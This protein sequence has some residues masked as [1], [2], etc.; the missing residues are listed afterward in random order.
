MPGMTVPPTRSG[1]AARAGWL[2]LLL[3]APGPAAA[4]VLYDVAPDAV[5]PFSSIDTLFPNWLMA[6][7]TSL[8]LLEG[9]D[10]ID[11]TC[12][13]N[14]LT[15]MNYGSAT[16]GPA[17][18]IRGMY[19][20]MTCGSKTNSGI[21]AMTFAGNWNIPLFGSRPVWTWAGSVPFGGD[22]CNNLGFACLC[23]PSLLIYTDISPCP[24]NGADVKLGP[25]YNDV[26]NPVWPGG[27]T[28]SCGYAAPWAVVTDTTV[29][30]IRY[31]TKTADQDVA[32]PGDTVNYTVFYGRPGTAALSS[33]TIF[34]TMPAYMHLI[35][36][37]DVP[38]ADPGYNPDPGPPL[39]LRWTI[40]PPLPVAGGPTGEIH[41]ALTVDWGNG[42]AFEPGS[43]D[44]GAPEGIRLQNIVEADYPTTSCAVKSVVT[45]PTATVVSRFRF[46]KVGTNDVLFSSSFG[47]P[48][49][50]MTYEIF[51]KNLSGQKTW[52]DARVWDSVPAEMDAWCP[53][54][55]FEDPCSGWTMTPSGC[56]AASPG[57]VV[58]GSVTLLTWRLDMPPGATLALRWRSQVKASDTAGSTALNKVSILAL[59][60]TGIVGGTGG[61]GAVKYFTHQAPI[62][63]PTMYVSYLA[64]AAGSN[65]YFQCCNDVL[66]FGTVAGAPGQTY[67]L[68]FFPLNQKT[69]FSLYEQEHTADAYAGL[70]GLSP[71]ITLAAG[72]CF[73]GAGWIP[74]CA[75]ERAP[76]WYLP[77][78][79]ATCAN[80]V[81][82]HNLYK[83]VSNSPLTWE[84]D[85]GDSH[86]GCEISTWVG[87]TSL[88]YAGY[89]AY[90][91]ARTCLSATNRDGLY[92]IN[93]SET[94]PTTIHVFEWNAGTLSWDYRT[95][96]ELDVESVWFYFPPEQNAYRLISS[97]TQFLLFKAL[98]LSGNPNT[99][100]QDPN[101]ENGYLVNAGTT[102]N[103]YGF[104]ESDAPKGGAIIVTNMGGAPAVF[105][106]YKYLAWNP[107]LP[108]TSTKHQN[109][110][111]VGS[112]GYWISKLTG[113]VAPAGLGAAGNARA[114]QQN[115]FSGASD[116]RSFY[117]VKLT[118]GGPIQVYS[119]Y[120]L[121][122][123]FG[124]GSVFHAGDT[125][126]PAGN[127]YWYSLTE[128]GASGKICP[129]PFW[130]TMTI[131]FFVPK[132]GVVIQA[133][134]NAG[135]TARYTTNGSD[136]CVSFMAL[137][138]PSAP[139]VYNW[140]VTSTGGSIAVAQY[141]ICSLH[142]KLFT[143]PFVAQGVHYSIIA[144]PVVFTGQSFW[145]TVIV[146]DVAGTTKDDYCGTTS[147]TST[148]PAAL[149]NGGPM[150]SFNY[151]WKSNVAG[152]CNTGTDNGVKVFVNVTFNKLGIQTIVATDTVDGSI[153][154]LGAI[155][156]VGADVKITKD[157]RLSIQASGDTV[158]FKVCWSNY[159]SA[160]AFSFVI[161]DAVPVGTTFVPE[162]TTG[163]FN[164]GSTDGVPVTVSYSTATSATPPPVF[165]DGLPPGATTR[166]LR[167]TVPMAGVQTTGCLC[168]RVSVN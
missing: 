154:G 131:D 141:Q 54:C 109:N 127:T 63:L 48:P 9:D 136:Q 42:E 57:R 124:G 106:V 25:G 112:S 52:W 138:P 32:A 27:M 161:T 2:L 79:Y 6:P 95:T 10:T 45:P 21:I 24:T 53:G 67:W 77:Q 149:I 89:A 8:Q 92:V 134:N 4:R 81:P 129:S 164:C 82:M 35:S 166:W 69:N 17:G 139:N 104:A 80:G 103:F 36:G 147:F 159:S 44:L 111:L 66:P 83:L 43:G 102:G 86:N 108:I 101:K 87:T 130:G 75:I 145:L 65:S 123:S 74:G 90:T 11:A 128:L 55:G 5:P 26:T 160:S 97:D 38:P 13:I 91:Y 98:P 152:S 20:L 148:D 51:I 40:P 163:A 49:D 33:I 47:V 165:T 155:M 1:P 150:D 34:D 162:A 105:N 113:E 61:S 93:T 114:Y 62:V 121:N 122:D 37:S 168:Y 56:A 71:S 39:R 153:V 18:D 125:S 144:P 64:M 73:G 84:L 76:A 68:S 140:K 50:E 46:W 88:T 135:Y 100:S 118:S 120:R 156:V 85:S 58:N 12:V 23:A 119:G 126:G 157:P 31:V 59:G 94:T 167:W 96:A 137:T 107:S 110:N 143:A 29:K 60:K 142:Q 22:P 14:G 19:F 116:E 117:K 30:T 158:Q 78:N 115:Y 99:N 16:G 133:Q 146:I 15:M 7:T 72:G 70:G 151:T 28:D 3:L 132:S 41:F